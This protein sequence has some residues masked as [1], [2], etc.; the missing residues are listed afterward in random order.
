MNTNLEFVLKKYKPTF[1]P[2]IKTGKG[3]EKIHGLDFTVTN[4]EMTEELIADTGHFSRW[5]NTKLQSAGSM[6]GIGGY[7]EDRVLYKR[8]KLFSGKDKSAVR[9]LHLG[10]DIWGPQGTAVYAPLGGMIHSFAYNNNFGDYGATIILQHNLD[11]TSFYTLYGHLSLADLTDVR[12]GKF[13]TRGEIFGHFG[14]PEENGDWPPHLHFQI[15]QDIGLWEGDYPGVCDPAAAAKFLKN[16]PDPG[17]M[18]NF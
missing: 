13:V 8:S 18:L 16:S 5:V 9:S 10:V 14:P 7:N 1:H 12:K 11:I 17:L 4:T 3:N 2:V 15:I 6:F